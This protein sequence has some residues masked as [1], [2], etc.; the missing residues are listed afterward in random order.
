MRGLKHRYPRIFINQYQVASFTDA[1]IETPC[2]IG[3]YGYYPSHLLQMR[4]LKPF[5]NNP[6]RNMILSHLL[7]MRG[8]KRVRSDIYVGGNTSH[9]LQMRGLKRMVVMDQTAA[10][11]SHLL[12]MRGLKL[13]RLRMLLYIYVASFTDAWI[14][15]IYPS[16]VQRFKTSRIFY[17]CVDWN[18][19][20]RHNMYG[21]SKSHLLQ[22]RGLKLVRVHYK[23]SET[24]RIFYRCVDWNL[25]ETTFCP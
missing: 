25:M 17:R 19:K 10:L 13:M 5:Q 4:G 2:W 23:A 18:F 8:L 9:L 15:T 24:S 6:T 16:S 7:Q 21:E 20:L 12:Q 3:Y 22:M 11:M 1:W 14:E